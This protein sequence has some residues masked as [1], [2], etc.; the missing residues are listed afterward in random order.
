MHYTYPITVQPSNTADKPVIVRCKLTTGIIRHVSIYFPRGCNYVVRVQ[1]H[2]DALQ[3]LPSNQDGY[4]TGNDY[5][6][7]CS[8]Y[9]PT[10]VFGNELIIRAWSRN[11]RYP[12][13]IC[14]YI[15][16]V[17][18]AEY[19]VLLAPKYLYNATKLLVELLRDMYV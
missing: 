15:D 9:F 6:V 16:L 17:E 5:A 2:T 3:L 13:T 10:D 14:V 12:H 8:C 18:P 1:I 7:E 19:E 4:Y 11:A